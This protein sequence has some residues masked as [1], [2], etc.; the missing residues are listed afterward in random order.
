M[1]AARDSR[2]VPEGLNSVAGVSEAFS[3]FQGI[4]EVSPIS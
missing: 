1:V 3:N 4:S 2:D